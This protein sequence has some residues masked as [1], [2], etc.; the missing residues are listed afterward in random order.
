MR[1]TIPKLFT[2]TL[3]VF[4]AVALRPTA[5]LAAVYTTSIDAEAQFKRVASERF[6][7]FVIDVKTNAILYFDV[8]VHEMH[9]H[10]VF[11]EIYKEEVNNERLVK[12]NRNY[13]EI[14]PE[15]I[16]GYLVHHVPQDVWTFGFYSG[17]RITP[18]HATHTLQRVQQSFYAGDKLKFLPDSLHQLTVAKALPDM[19]Q[20]TRD[21]LYKSAP[22]QAFNPGKRVGVLRIVTPDEASRPTELKLTRDQIVILPHDLPDI[23][24]VSGIVTETFSTPLAHV[25]LRARAWGIPHVG[26]VGASTRFADLQ[27]KHVLFEAT[28]EACTLR[29]ATDDEIAQWLEARDKA[30]AVRI[31]P[32]DSGPRALASLH[33]NVEQRASAYGAKAANLARVAVARL[34]GVDVPKGVTIPIAWYLEHMQAHGLSPA[35][36]EAEL[37]PLRA[38]IRRAPIDPELRAR[39]RNALQRLKLPKG[40][41]IFVRSSTNAEDLPGFNGAGLY[42]TVPNVRGED[43]LVEAIKQVWS[44]VWNDRAFRERA[45]F[46]IPQDNVGAAVLLQVGVNATAA[47]VLITADL[48]D[49]DDARTYTINAKWGLGIRV[50]QGKKVP[51]QILYD[52]ST[53]SAKVLSRS[54]EKTMLVFDRDGGVREVHA[55]PAKAILTQSRVNVLADAATAMQRYLAWSQPLD[56]EWLFEGERLWIVQARPYIAGH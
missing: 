56:V 15:F 27:G 32:L 22:Y 29:V 45:H 5:A 21:A 4:S 41:G 39:M 46:G 50:V 26:F 6:T 25:A 30:K 13:S 34:P 55:P 9:T 8:N 2:A 3:L 1:R 53:R 47:G 23:A 14:K 36:S 49:P 16:L 51:E 7:K 33:A 17:D 35:T 10:F 38:A 48:F 28:P 19:P 24:V 12:F 42:D 18:A 31:P 44:S 54:E 52:V 40:A 43:A 20:A 11:A 37:A